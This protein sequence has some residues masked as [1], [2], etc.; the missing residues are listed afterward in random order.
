MPPTSHYHHTKIIFTIGPATCAEDRIEALIRAGADVCRLNMAH[1]TLEWTHETVAR[2]HAVCQRT[3]RY[4]AVMMDIKGP[5]IRTGFLEQAIQLAP[6]EILELWART[7][8]PEGPGPHRVD[9]NYRDLPDDVHPGDTMLVD[10][11][12]IRLEVLESHPDF[13]KTRVLTG[14]E[15][16]SRRHINLPGV[17]V[18]LPSLTDK[19]HSD[20]DCGIELGVDFFALSFV[21]N[22][23][24]VHELRHYLEERNSPARII[25]KIE[26]QAGLRNLTEIVE[27]A[28][29]VMVARGDLGIEIPFEKLPL[30]QNQC[31]KA[32]LAAGKPVIV[33]T[34]MLESM[35]E[36]PMPTRAEITDIANAVR[37]QADCVMLSGETTTGKYPLECV[38]V[39]KRVIAAT[40][41]L[42]TAELNR[43]I[44]LRQPKAKLLRSTAV[45]AQE[46][47]NAGIVL[48][49][50]SGFTAHVAAALRPNGVPIYAF[51]DV[52]ST[53]RQMLMLWGIEPFL[54]D[55]ADDMEETIHRACRTLVE[56]NWCRPGDQV[57]LVTNI[58]VR[59]K[60]VDTLQIRE[61]D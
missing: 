23:A 19:D 41:T 42:N 20:I 5:E 14:G 21:R 16:G 34:H 9:V 26:D 13:I 47:E 57:A 25:A 55:F 50:R 11:G 44:K 59:G 30:V 4:M 48:F 60:V 10:S 43:T 8:V 28:D 40:E 38:E 61:I 52:P 1:A 31:V 12:L 37:E 17:E 18:K 24:A 36:N 46:L 32:C 56:T 15:L 54:I 7:T 45:L 29:A 6:G 33:A 49:T 35:V 22:A 2:V 51:T 27:A 53:F 39:M 58:V 3:G